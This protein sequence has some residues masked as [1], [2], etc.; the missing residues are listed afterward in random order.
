V[1]LRIVGMGLAVPPHALSQAEAADVLVSLLPEGGRARTVQALY[2][3]SGI[4]KRHSVLLGVPE[5]GGRPRQSLYTPARDAADGGPSTAVRMRLFEDHAPPLGAA[6]AEAALGDAGMAPDEITHLVTVSCTG[7]FAPGLDAALV[8]R[9]A[10]RRT[11]QRTHV[12]FMGCHGALNGLRVASALAGADPD[13]RVL[14]CCVE[15]CS[16]HMGY[17]WDAD[18]LVANALFADGAAALVGVGANGQANVRAPAWRVTASGTLLFPDSAD[19]MTWRIGDHG[20]R[21]TLSARVP[22]LIREHVGGWLSEW[23]RERGMSPAD[24]R[25]WAVHPGGPR[26]LSAFGHGMGLD[27]LAF[28]ASREVLAE[29]GNMSS[30]TLLFILH[31][32]REAGAG[33]PVVALA[34]GPGLVAEVALLV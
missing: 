18:T 10:L 23:L 28:A 20:F 4:H 14:L 11:V 19:A 34:F 8:Q 25:T 1:S 5:G 21:M 2:A 24:V 27:P 29:H 17:G 6:A 9:L 32:L 12:G 16:L 7:F 31:R 3:R 26:V 33:A 22:D 13:A 30:A 15:L